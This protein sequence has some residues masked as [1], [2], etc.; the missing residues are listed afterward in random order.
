MRDDVAVPVKLPKL[1]FVVF[2]E[3]AETADS[4]AVR[5]AALRHCTP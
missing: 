5:L 2:R 3:T 1:Q 4:E